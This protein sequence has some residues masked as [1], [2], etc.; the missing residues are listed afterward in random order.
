MNMRQLALTLFL[1]LGLFLLS[2]SA[3]AQQIEIKG[4]K[5]GNSELSGTTYGPVIPADTLWRIASR[6]RQ[7]KNLSVY[8]VMQGIYQLNPNAFE[9]NNFNHL[10]DGSILNLPSERYIAR[11]NG[12]Q[13]RIKA[14]KDDSNWS[15]I[16]QNGQPDTAV[17]ARSSGAVS[18]DDLSETKQ[19][20][21]DRLSELD[22]EQNR[23][24][25]AI[26]Q[27]FSESISAV[28]SVLGE[29]RQLL[30]R[31][32]GVDQD[33]SELKGRVD[34]EIQTQMDQM[35][36]LQN[37][38]LVISK[39][40][41]MTRRTES[42]KTSFDWLT[43][44]ITLIAITVLLSLSLLAAFA[45]WLVRRNKD[46]EINEMTLTDDESHAAALEQSDEMDELADALSNELSDEL[47]DSDEED[48]FADEELLDDVLSEE[49][50]ESL[51]E[52]ADDDF[53][54]FDDLGDENL[55]PIIEA[56]DDSDDELL[57]QE[58]LDSLFD[59]DDELLAQIDE[60]ADVP[61]E[62]DELLAST[63][64]EEAT[65]VADDSEEIDE[66]IK[67]AV[68][69]VKPIVDDEQDKPEISIDEL[70]DQPEI[71]LPDSVI[72]ANSD[73]MND[74]MLQN[75]DKEISQQNKQLDSVAD[76]LLS[77]IE[78]LEQMGGLL[79]GVED[80]SESDD[81]E[82][83][84]PV[85]SNKQHAIQELESVTDDIEDDM[86]DELLASLDDEIP[87]LDDIDSDSDNGFDD[88]ELEEALKTFDEDA[89]DSDS[90]DEEQNSESKKSAVE[91]DDLPGLGDWLTD[92]G[93]PENKAIDE[94]E[95]SSFDELLDGIEEDDESL[96]EET[97]ST[98]TDENNID[99]SGLDFDALLT[100]IDT[101]ETLESDKK[102]TETDESKFVDV[103]DLIN[104][105]DEADEEPVEKKLNLDAAFSSYE[106]LPGETQMVDVDGDQGMGAKLDLAQAYIETDE[107]EAAKSLLEEVVDKGD[108]SQQLEAKELLATFS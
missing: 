103:E 101:T 56:S 80:E 73:V 61:E 13:A 92:E 3:G 4:P 5:N 54:S 90:L 49:L 66:P 29:N 11:I 8:Q 104:E 35:L 63:P 85:D 28:Q 105:S 72:E 99:E 20:I 32:D 24:F 75:L 9:D 52:A 27:Q 100:D 79:D 16:V 42:E 53:E 67:A 23:Q 41:E 58:D 45:I 77:E 39:D 2:N 22:A 87:T 94:L 47:V 31:L 6:Y 70:L 91:L 19:V 65:A 106:G 108:E 12:E 86:S 14:E 84:E 7:N 76:N 60:G 10:K 88:N 95:S 21:E 37:E 40:A 57:E 69:E 51:D 81:P 96:A 26:R 102:V 78:Q 15:S 62:A 98:G 83:S 36:E 93:Q 25:M 74:E 68:E 18:K 1:S 97:L 64:A 71:E 33:I 30:E 50:K 44:P 89:F 43:N 82:S 34:V 17:K 55:E 46:S 107:I 48:L 38:L 59:E